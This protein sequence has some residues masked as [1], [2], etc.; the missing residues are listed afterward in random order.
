MGYDYDYGLATT[1]NADGTTSTEPG[2][3][4]HSGFVL[5]ATEKITGI[6]DSSLS[7]GYDDLGRLV[8]AART[9]SYKYNHSYGYD[10]NDNR[11]SVTKNGTTVTATYD[12]ANQLTSQGGVSY[13]YDRNGNLV[14]YNG[15]TL[16]YDASNKWTGGTVNGSSVS[17]GY[18]GQGR[19]V[20]RT[21]GTGRTDYWYDQTGLVLETGAATSTYLRGLG[22]ELLSRTRGTTLVNYGTDNLGSVR[23]LLDGQTMV[24]TY[25]YD[26]WG[27]K[28][29]STGTYYNPY[30]YT[31][32][33]LDAATDLYQ[34]GAR[35]YQPETGRFTQLD[36]LGCT[37]DDGQ[38]YSYTMG[39][40]VNYT[41]PSGL[42]H[43]PG[44]HWHGM[45]HRRGYWFEKPNH[46]S[47]G[48]RGCWSA[49]WAIGSFSIF[50]A[51]RA[52][53]AAGLI[54]ES[55][56]FVIRGLGVTNLGAWDCPSLCD[57]LMG[58]WHFTSY[59]YRVWYD[60][61]DAYRWELLG[62]KRW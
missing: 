14:S 38:R 62:V 36:P 5:S 9:G 37:I 19:R 34:M 52:V 7:Y 32:T 51:V 23:A 45:T 50:K 44:R 55:V 13:S 21:I 2:A 49:C 47:W 53:R 59:Y 22:G 33:Y 61:S 16:S 12:G 27:E 18:D 60:G 43:L 56:E 24:N 8:N 26:P 54:T 29:G 1:T 31:G 42:W 35:Y 10:A 30:Q 15:N 4:Y 57:R 6:A 3:N 11:T 41:D 58:R 48:Y 28:V 40:P 17:F 25:S 46:D 39:N 20:S